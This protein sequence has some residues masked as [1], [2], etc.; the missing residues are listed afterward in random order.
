MADY[1][2]LDPA[3]TPMH[4]HLAALVPVDPG[5]GALVGR[6]EIEMPIEVDV[7]RDGTGVLSLGSS[8]PLYYQRTGYR[9]APHRIRVTIVD[10]REV[11][12]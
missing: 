8:P 1:C 3:L 7:L 4:E 5:D 2:G 12:P 9:S 6:I 10:E 11:L